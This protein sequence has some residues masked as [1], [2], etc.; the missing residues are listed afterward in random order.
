MVRDAYIPQDV[1]H[2]RTR[3]TS[4]DAVDIQP[5]Q[6]VFDGWFTTSVL[7]NTDIAYKK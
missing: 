7:C 1:L 6:V 2:R 5:T 3:V 4:I